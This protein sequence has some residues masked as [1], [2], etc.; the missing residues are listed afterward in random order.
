M[1]LRCHEFEPQPELQ[2]STVIVCVDSGLLAHGGCPVSYP[3]SF[4]VGSAPGVFCHKHKRLKK[5][6]R[7]DVL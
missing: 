5:Y 6:G 4:I 3:Q 7:K 1:F 2:F